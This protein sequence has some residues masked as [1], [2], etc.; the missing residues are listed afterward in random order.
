MGY[1]VGTGSDIL[2]EATL[3]VLPRM[4][5]RVQKRHLS[6]AHTGMPDLTAASASPFI[7]SLDTGF[8]LGTAVPPPP[9][10]DIPR[11]SCYSNKKRYPGTDHSPGPA[12]EEGETPSGPKLSCKRVGMIRSRIW[13]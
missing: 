11:G 7:S 10:P 12:P 3:S 9:P 2:E 13:P 6:A 5:Y 4:A 8:F 1:P